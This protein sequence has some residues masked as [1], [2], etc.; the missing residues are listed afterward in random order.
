MK[1][2]QNSG[3]NV[4]IFLRYLL[5]LIVVA[6]VGFFFYRE[7]QE[8]WDTVSV[9]HLSFNFYYLAAAIM[10]TAAGFLLETYIWHIFVNDYLVRK[11]TF[12]DS[13]ALYNTTAM[14]KYIPGKVWSYAAQITLTSSRGISKSLLIYINV[15][16]FICLIFSSGA[17]ALYYYLFYL[18]TLPLT[19][20]AMICGLFF[21]LFFIFVRRNT[22][23]INYLINLINRIFRRDIQPVKIRKSLLL[24]IQLLYLLDYIPAGCGMYLLAQG[25]GLD[26]PFSSIAALTAAL[27]VSL[28]S[29]YIAFFSPGGLGVREGTMLLILKQFSTVHAALILPLAMRLIYIIIELFLGA[30]GILLSMKSGLFAACLKTGFKK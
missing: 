4:K 11:L 14:L 7:F 10:V 3:A 13:M 19:I 6:L 28:V 5:T 29:G 27:A 18:K 1:R 26:I 21:I 17:Y 23:I 12:R 25:I 30:I 20:S 15:I 16:C 24:Y 8:N 22:A 9:H 2:K